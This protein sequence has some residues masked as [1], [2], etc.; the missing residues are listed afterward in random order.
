M[1][2]GAGAIYNAPTFAFEYSAHGQNL[3]FHH[4]VDR[5]AKD[6]SEEFIG[7]IATS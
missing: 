3:I 5:S 2:F 7:D 4:W 1:T 6:G